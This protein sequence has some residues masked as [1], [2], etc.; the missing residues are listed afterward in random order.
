[1][2]YHAREHMLN[3]QS[4]QMRYITFGNGSKPFV[5]IQGLNTRSIK[6]MA[7]PLAYMYRIFAKEYQVYLFDRREN[8]EA[9]ITVKELA[10]DIA[11]AMDALGISDADVL[12]VSQGGM[13]GQYLAMERPDLVHKLVLA[14][15][16]S[17]NN[18]TVITTV[19]GWMKMVR[20]NNMRQ[21][22]ADMMDKMYSDKYKNKYR[23]FLPLLTVLQRP[24]DPQ[25]FL[26]LAGACLTCHTYEQLDKI[27][28]PVFVIG[29]RKDKVVGAE[30][31]IEIAK[32]LDCEIFMYDEFGHAAYEEAPDFNKRV[33]VFL[34]R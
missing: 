31:S 27:K 26:A 32:K 7:V 6:G 22:V 14:V 3:I 19:N 21:L 16:L 29:G 2:L 23:L 13:I 1:M 15:T 12:G 30:G 5:M 34:R 18:E 11:A 25:R 8:I 33:Y 9:G 4:G 28:C 10:E 24:K 17:R 20:Q